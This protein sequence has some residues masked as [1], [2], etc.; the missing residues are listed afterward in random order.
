MTLTTSSAKLT[1][2]E[3]RRRSQ[4]TDD[5]LVKRGDAEFVWIMDLFPAQPSAQCSADIIHHRNSICKTWV[6]ATDAV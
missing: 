2:A 3:V 5:A 6:A 4:M 1:S